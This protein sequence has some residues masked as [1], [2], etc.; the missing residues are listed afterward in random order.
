MKRQNKTRSV[1]VA[2]SISLNYIAHRRGQSPN[3]SPSALHHSELKTVTILLAWQ[4][5]SCCRD[6]WRS[7]LMQNAVI[8]APSRFVEKFLVQ[9][10]PLVTCY[11]PLFR[12]PSGSL[13]CCLLLFRWR[14]WL[15]RVV[16][17]QLC[18]HCYCMYCTW[19][20][21]PICIKTPCYPVLPSVTW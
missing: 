3:T 8:W 14:W 2:L 15:V 6:S 4:P 18:P 10:F 5:S 19:R 12:P 7:I 17:Q 13:L 16:T 11:P 9:L 20:L 21:L 1:T